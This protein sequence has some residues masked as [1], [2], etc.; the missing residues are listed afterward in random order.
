[1]KHVLPKILKYFTLGFLSFHN[2]YG[3]FLVSGLKYTL[4]T[5]W[6]AVLMA[7]PHKF[8]AT[9]LLC[10][11]A[12]AISWITLFF[13]STTPFCWGVIEAENSWEIPDL[14]LND[15]IY[16]F[17]NSLPWSF[18]I[19]SIFKLFSFCSLVHK[20]SMWLGASDL[21]HRRMIQVYLV[22]SSTTTMMYLLPLRDSVLVKPI[23]FRC[24]SSNGLD[25]ADVW[26]PRCLAFVYFPS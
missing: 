24:R 22:K 2:S 13:L 5:V 9:S 15:S 17:L 14:V 6:H 21:D 18:R 25:V 4:L 20:A 11:M 8:L 12:L 10:S 7:Y 1:M 16:E 26:V 3:V 23:R 19:L